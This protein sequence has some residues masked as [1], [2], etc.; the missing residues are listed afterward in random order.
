MV[1]NVL[2]KVRPLP[3]P[4]WALFRTSTTILLIYSGSQVTSKYVILKHFTVRF[5]NYLNCSRFTPFCFVGHQ[6]TIHITAQKQIYFIKKTITFLF[7]HVF[8]FKG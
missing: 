7:A 8:F 4:Q 3:P 2:F 5:R 1:L 6:K